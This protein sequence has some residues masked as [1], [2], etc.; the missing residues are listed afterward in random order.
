VYDALTTIRPYKKA[1]SHEETVE[2][3]KGEASKYDPE[4][5]RLFLDNANEFNEIRKR[6]KY[7]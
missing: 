1:M 6:F 3:M 7:S 5:F 4:L 2:I